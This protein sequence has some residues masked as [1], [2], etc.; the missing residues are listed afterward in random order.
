M[1]SQRQAASCITSIAT[2][3]AV[4]WW[5]ELPAPG[6]CANSNEKRGALGARREP[7]V[8]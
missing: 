7:L 8:R 4:T 6:P 2:W 1:S 5:S 3:C